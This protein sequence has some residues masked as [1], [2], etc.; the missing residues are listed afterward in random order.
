MK[1]SAVV[2]KMWRRIAAGG[3]TGREGERVIKV[4]EVVVH[5][6]IAVES[7]PIST[8]LNEFRGHVNSLV[9]EVFNDVLLS[10]DILS[11][12][13]IMAQTHR[14]SGLLPRNI[15]E[16]SIHVYSPCF[17]DRQN[18]SE[19][20]QSLLY[21]PFLPF[22]RITYLIAPAAQIEFSFCIFAKDILPEILVI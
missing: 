9:V 12:S 20:V 11:V 22:R 6:K 15:T 1:E 16:K 3:L 10:F 5:R 8:S 13:I 2:P 14:T 18:G 17:G 4:T 19:A 21:H 7:F